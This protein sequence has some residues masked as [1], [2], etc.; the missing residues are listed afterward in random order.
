M[1]D[2]PNLLRR[3]GLFRGLDPARLDALIRGAEETR[4]V[5]GAEIF[6]EGEFG[7]AMYVVLEGAVKIYTR[8]RDSR[9]IVLARLEPGDY[10][11]EQSLLPGSS[12]RRNASV[13]AAEA[14]RLARISRAGFQAVLADNDALRERLAD[15]GAGQ[16]RNNLQHLSPLAR[17][18][19]LNKIASLRR[20]LAAGEILFRQGDEADALYLVSAG[21]L[22]AWR[23]HDG[24]RTLIGT[25]ERGGCVG[26]LALIRRDLRSATV[27][28]DEAAEVVTIPRSAF[29]D[30]Y[31]GSRAVRELLTTIQRAYELPQRGILTQ[32]AG[33]FAGQECITTIYHLSDGGVFAAHR[34]VGQPLYALECLGAVAAETLT[35]AEGE[36]SREIRLDSKGVAI[37]ITA[38]G[39]WT[40]VHAFHL[41]VL[42]G[43]RISFE[44]RQ[45]FLRSGRFFAAP[46]PASAH[47]VCHCVNVTDEKLRALIR[48]G[49]TTFTRLQEITS[50]G[51]VCG[52]CIPVVAEMLGAE[53]WVLADVVAEVDEA[54]GI[55]SFELVPR[56]PSYPEARPGQ[57]IVV[58]GVVGGLPLRRPYTL[59]SP[60]RH[61]GRLRITVK[62]EQGGAFS[63]WLFNR[64]T[65]GE[66]LRIT[67]PRG[68]YVIDLTR[69]SPAVCLVAGIGVT[70]A[71]A[72]ARTLETLKRPAPLLVH[73]SGRSRD[74]MACL[75]ELES[76][77]QRSAVELVI[78]E[79][80]QQGRVKAAE[81]E[82]LAA[83]FP[84]ADWYLCGPP[85]YLHEVGQ[86]LRQVRISPERIHVEAFT[87]VGSPPDDVSRATAEERAA[88]TRY[89]LATPQRNKKKPAIDLLRGLGR[90]VVK[91][92][93]S[94]LSNWQ[95]RSV[96]INP[97]RW[98]ER[99]IARSA[100]IDP[101]L[102]FEHVAI[103]SALSHGPFAY[104]TQG[105][106]RLQELGT[107]NR[108]LARIER[109][110]GRPVAPNTPDGDTFAYIV[111]SAPFPVFP[112]ECRV[113]TGW[114][115]P[116]PGKVMPAYVTR[117]RTAIEHL[118]RHTDASDRGPLPY[119]FVQ[120]ITGRTDIKSC[121]GRSAAGVI[122]GP[123]HDNATWAEDRAI[124]NDMLG[125]YLV[126]GF[127]AGMSAAMDEVSSIIDESLERDREAVI[128]LN[129]LMSKVAYTIIVR[130]VF[131]DVDIAEMHALGRKLSEAVRTLFTYLFEFVMGRQS[132]PKEYIQAQSDAR[133]TVRSM[134]DLIR[135]LDRKGKLTE[136]QRTFPPVRLVL[137]TA[138]APDGAYEQLYS[139]ILPLVI[140]GHETTGYTMSWAIYE[141]NRRPELEA[142]ILAEIAEYRA[143]HANAT[144]TTARYDERPMTWAL[145]AEVLRCHP[146]F[147]SMGRTTTQAGTVPPDP[148][149]GIGGFDYPPDT[150]M[151]FSI[152]AINRDPRRW[153]DPHEFR[154][155]RWLSG[156]RE[157]MSTSEKGHAVRATIREREQA[158]D[159]LPFSDGP[160]RCPGQ[161]FN[162]HEFFVVMD[163]LLPRY[164]FEFVDGTKTVEHSNTMIVGPP[165][166]SLAVRIRRR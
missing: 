55:R 14:V 26:E 96:Q 27:I 76:T 35:W 59:S 37:G 83:R 62:C 40:D 71:V 4:A 99:R 145:L 29:E 87:A 11:G 97:V 38:C 89:L 28:A 86:M 16:V 105:L 111:P 75:S 137:E 102:P 72:A 79:T 53:E 114:V 90:A 151:V 144:L 125:F 123:F 69:E 34:V 39:E 135:E 104:Q 82:K 94:P 121:P 74:R 108:E 149:T 122:A 47:V 103:V 126:D 110:A 142:S 134:I 5:A 117:S 101:N 91:A 30:A 109:A 36:Q 143:A 100:G 132:I 33:T 163:A 52:G 64:R 3:C 45:E 15:I 120:Q 131:G 124:A 2:I 93:N 41:L 77:A 139:F 118:L 159:W 9:E 133:G 42:D 106:D 10:F 98:L 141:M 92:A 60:C 19:G 115:R 66:P 48:Q 154:V 148:E 128:D 153:P 54:A 73:Y 147:Q 113:D 32:H 119:H 46:V 65:K 43:G 25:V 81:I 12:G 161:H 164:R 18:I 31:R 80:A 116:A 51:T 155:E 56:D 136:K 140:A 44:D 61:G 130:A 67:R 7:D 22:A 23:E 112:S 107:R 8:D 84:G 57:H 88:V 1:T 138:S 13:R 166:G 6:R 85:A 127:G 158:M 49:A 58:E 146:P 162:A 70:P 152:I 78:R 129:V 17:G 24:A 68:E 50:C 20:S 165:A 160:G 21:R 157:G 95:V 156:V 150:M 63:P